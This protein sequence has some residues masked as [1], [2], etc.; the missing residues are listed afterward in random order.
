[1]DDDD[2]GHYNVAWVRIPTRYL[3]GVFVELG[4]IICAFHCVRTIFW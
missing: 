1:M 2:V 4:E 3:S